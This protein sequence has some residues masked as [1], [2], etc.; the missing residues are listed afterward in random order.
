MK[1]L[2]RALPRPIVALACSFLA[3]LPIAAADPDETQPTKP[4][5]HCRANPATVPTG[6]TPQFPVA[7]LAFDGFIYYYATDC[8]IDDHTG[9]LTT[10]RQV[11]V[12]PCDENPTENPLEDPEDIPPPPLFEAPD[13]GVVPG[14]GSQPPPTPGGDAPAT[15]SP[16]TDGAAKSFSQFDGES[17][18]QDA[19]PARFKKYRTQPDGTPTPELSDPFG[20]LPFSTAIK[21]RGNDGQQ[22]VFTLMRFK[23]RNG[24]GQTIE[25]LVLT[26]PRSEF[27][28]PVTD[29]NGNQYGVRPPRTLGARQPIAVNAPLGQPSTRFRDL[30]VPGLNGGRPT[31]I[32]VVNP[33]L[34]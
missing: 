29:D 18:A 20:G 3:G 26:L 15:D 5:C 10:P 21:L 8:C 34:N 14:D 1:F 2:R 33:P 24:R 27:D 17:L 9:V 16:A 28:V 23:A 4:A 31:K 12:T 25:F 22:R 6:L 7:Y 32:L 19:P 11:P 30:T 13:Q